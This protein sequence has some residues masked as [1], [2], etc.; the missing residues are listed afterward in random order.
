MTD[1][2]NLK[3][4]SAQFFRGTHRDKVCTYVFIRVSAYMCINICIYTVFLKKITEDVCRLQQVRLLSYMCNSP[5]VILATKNGV[6]TLWYLM[7]QFHI[8]HQSYV[9]CTP[10]CIEKEVD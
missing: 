9:S 10:S 3:I 7:P 8:L 6:Q 1:F 4:K 2:M 5:N